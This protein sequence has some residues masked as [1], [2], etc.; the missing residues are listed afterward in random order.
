MTFCQLST[1][2]CFELGDVRDRRLHLDERGRCVRGVSGV[3]GHDSMFSLQSPTPTPTPSPSP[4][5]FL[6]RVREGVL[7]RLLQVG[8]ASEPTGASSASYRM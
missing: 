5:G 8:V 7:A 1:A 6:A 4:S 2:G 3:L